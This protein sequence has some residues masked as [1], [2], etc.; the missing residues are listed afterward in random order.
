MG[1]DAATKAEGAAKTWKG[2][3]PLF[4]VAARSCCFAVPISL[5][6]A[7][8]LRCAANWCRYTVLIFWCAAYWHQGAGNMELDAAHDS[9]GAAKPI[10][11][12]ANS[13]GR[14]IRPEG[15]TAYCPGFAARPGDFK[16]EPG[17]W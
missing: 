6:A 13:P 3:L 2:I 5:H 1:A 11:E 16:G 12:A 14:E 7:K 8:W 15:R 10:T 9:V 4:Q 17:P